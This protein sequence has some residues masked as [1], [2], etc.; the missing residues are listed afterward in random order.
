ME[1]TPAPRSLE[2]ADVTAARAREEAPVVS[3]L[4]TVAE[5]AEEIIA[6]EISTDEEGRQWPTSVEAAIGND[7]AA[8]GRH[9]C[10][11]STEAP[12]E[13]DGARGKTGVLPLSMLGKNKK[14]SYIDTSKWTEWHLGVLLRK[15]G[16]LEYANLN[17]GKKLKDLLLNP[18]Q[19]EV[20]ASLQGLQVVIYRGMLHV[21]L[22]SNS[23]MLKFKHAVVSS[24]YDFSLASCL[25]AEIKLI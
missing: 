9:G 10:R 24:S 25:V 11:R 7:G 13:E 12:S 18:F 6:K 4:K 19:A 15:S 16:I 14:R 3:L 23:L 2:L 5:S 22:E 20:I 1:E 17:G 21:I 8:L